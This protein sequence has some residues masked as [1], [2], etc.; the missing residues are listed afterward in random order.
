[1]ALLEFY[2]E[3]CPHCI[4]MA[5]LVEQLKGEGFAVEQFETWHHPENA[6]KHKEL[7]NGKCGGVP[8]FLNTDSGEFICGSVEYDVLKNWANGKKV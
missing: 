3:G 2:G 6:K 1:M 8:F 7:D 4:H 5:P